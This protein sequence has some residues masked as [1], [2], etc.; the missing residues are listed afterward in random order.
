MTG[1][2]LAGAGIGGTSSGYGGQPSGHVSG[3]DLSK[4]YRD[5]DRDGFVVDDKTRD[6]AREFKEDVK[7]LGRSR[8]HDETG[9][10]SFASGDATNLNAMRDRDRDG[11]VADD[12]M[13][14]TGNRMGDAMTEL[15][16]DV[17]DW[18]RT[19]EHDDPAFT[20]TGSYDS[21]DRDK[22]G[23]VVDDKMRD[24]GNRMSSSAREMKED[25]KDLGRNREHDSSARSHD[26]RD[27]DRD[28]WVVDDKM[29]EWGR[30][31]KDAVSNTGSKL[32]QE[33][34]ELRDEARN[35]ERVM[36]DAERRRRARVYDRTII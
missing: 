25:V 16:E 28:G 15:K 29:R 21:R 12:K 10:G 23:Y 24:A 27:K 36:T 18:G 34:R 11:Y 22:D 26:P 8:E 31:I 13:R 14:N 35:N 19:R 20:S 33:G 3:H 9:Y 6:A 17:K 4:D 1:A 32:K 2:G 30:D 7:D 5:R